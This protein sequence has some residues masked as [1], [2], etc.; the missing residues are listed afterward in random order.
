MN[1]EEYKKKFCTFGEQPLARGGQKE[2]YKATHTEFGNVVVKVLFSVDGRSLREIDI[3]RENEFCRVPKIYRVDDLEVNGCPTKVIVEEYI[4]GVCLREIIKT[5][6][7]YTLWEAADFLEEALKFIDEISACDIVHRDIKP[8]NII[9]CVDG[10]LT[11]LDFGIA[12]ILG[13]T[14]LTATNQGGPN[15]PGYAA[16]EQFTGQKDRLD[17]R[18]DLFSI[19]VVTYELVTGRNPFRENAR[20]PFQILFNTATITP[21][22]LHLKGDTQSQFAGLLS[23]MMSRQL[24]ARPKNAQQAMK[25]LAIA[26]STFEDGE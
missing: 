11:F 21:V 3:V 2:V 12:R 7:R 6:K 1:F 26:R 25:W 18:A 24:Y 23:A 22:E 19:G 14:S 13:A 20:D 10:S 4:A 17:T 9:V 16:P 15:T 5:G 8:E